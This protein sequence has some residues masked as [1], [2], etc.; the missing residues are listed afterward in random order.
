M[1]PGRLSSCTF[2]TSLCSN[3]YCSDT[4]YGKKYFTEGTV[5]VYINKV[6]K[7]YSDICINNSTLR[8]YYCE[9]YNVMNVSYNCQYGCLSIH[10]NA[11]CRLRG[12]APGRKLKSSVG[13]KGDLTA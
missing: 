12:G 13:P 5:N 9:G 4:D 2:D 7:S 6:L 11:M 3:D 10:N 1:P 8:E